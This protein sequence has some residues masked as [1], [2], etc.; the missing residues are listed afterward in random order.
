VE[1]AERHGAIEGTE[2]VLQ[3]LDGM[4]EISDFLLLSGQIELTKCVVGECFF[5]LLGH[6]E[7][8]AVGVVG[9]V[10]GDIEVVFLIQIGVHH[11]NRLMV[12]NVETEEGN[13]TEAASVLSNLTFEFEHVLGASLVHGD[14][15]SDTILGID[16][17][18]QERLEEV[19]NPLTLAVEHQTDH[20]LESGAG[21]EE[22]VGE[23][24]FDEGS[25]RV[26]LGDT[27]K[28]I[29]NHEKREGIG[30]DGEGTHAQKTSGAIVEAS[31]LVSNSLLE[32]GRIE[33]GLLNNWNTSFRE[34]S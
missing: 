8:E 9:H 33:G 15:V 30:T 22:V 14:S 7:G 34:R 19:S 31:T 17:F 1:S 6:L 23:L 18:F 24:K 20:D 5:L 3:L 21:Q 16:V 4:L 11:A 10:V 26:H 29:I 2:V 25:L 12:A 27:K 13:D 32:L 28:I